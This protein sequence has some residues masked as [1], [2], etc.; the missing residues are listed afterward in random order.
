MSDIDRVEVPKYSF[1]DKRKFPGPQDCDR[2]A[3][4]VT[5]ANFVRPVDSPSSRS[6]TVI[7]SGCPIEPLD[8][9]VTFIDASLDADDRIYALA[10]KAHIDLAPCSDWKGD[11]PKSDPPLVMHWMYLREGQSLMSLRVCHSQLNERQ[12]KRQLMIMEGF[13]K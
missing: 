1:F 6:Y 4:A 7:C 2:M 5:Q 10:N 11:V 12:T 8:R 13:A 9:V 3:Q